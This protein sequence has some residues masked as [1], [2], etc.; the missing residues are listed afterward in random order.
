MMKKT[1]PIAF[2]CLLSILLLL[3]TTIAVIDENPVTSASALLKQSEHNVLQE[4]DQ[5]DLIIDETAISDG[6]QISVKNIQ[7]Y[8]K[9][10]LS[11]ISSNADDSQITNQLLLNL[12]YNETEISNMG[13]DSKE[14]F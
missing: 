7:R 14:L 9:H 2:L 11:N 6:H 5:Y 13:N 3:V 1:I 12:G 10:M 4:L 8:K